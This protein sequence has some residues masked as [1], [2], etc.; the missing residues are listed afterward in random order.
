MKRKEVES[1]V[2]LRPPLVF[3]FFFGGWGGVRGGCAS[4]DSQAQK[5]HGSSARLPIDVSPVSHELEG[6]NQLGAAGL[7]APL[8]QDMG[9]D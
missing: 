4:A 8:H 6:T 1:L 5:T 3:F 7:L 9:K 2:V